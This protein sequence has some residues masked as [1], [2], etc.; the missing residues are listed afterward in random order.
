LTGSTDPRR[1]RVSRHDD[2]FQASCSETT[3]PKP[4]EEGIEKAK[5]GAVHAA[6]KAEEAVEHAGHKIKEGATAA[7]NKL[8]EAGE[9]VKDAGHKAD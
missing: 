9:K 3:V 7:G 6:H 5:D 1:D 8:E 2:C 4:L